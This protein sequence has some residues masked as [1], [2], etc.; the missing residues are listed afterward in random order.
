VVVHLNGDLLCAH[1]RLAFE[2]ETQYIRHFIVTVRFGGDQFQQVHHVSAAS[3][4]PRKHTRA[5]C[6]TG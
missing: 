3:D 2:H 4:P 1:E 6:A 5:A